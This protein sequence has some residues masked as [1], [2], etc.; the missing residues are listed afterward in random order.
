MQRSSITNGYHPIIGNGFYYSQSTIQRI[1]EQL[2]ASAENQVPIMLP[3][4]DVGSDTRPHSVLNDPT[5]GFPDAPD[6]PMEART[7][8]NVEGNI[9]AGKNAL[10]ELLSQYKNMEICLEPMADW[11]N[12]HGMDPLRLSYL[13]PTKYAAAFQHHVFKTQTEIVQK[14]W[15]QPVRLIERSMESSSNVFLEALFEN[16]FINRLDY[17]I[18][19]EDYKTG[20]M[21]N[22]HTGTIYLDCD[23][24]T[25][26]QRV[27]RN[28]RIEGLSTYTYFQSVNH[29]YERYIKH[30]IDQGGQVIIIDT[31]GDW[32]ELAKISHVI[33]TCIEK[34]DMETLFSYR[35]QHLQDY[36]ELRQL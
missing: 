19:K 16:E 33:G 35:A 13:N 20:I 36:F 30:L 21:A 9:A 7:L 24:D 8:I 23:P 12:Y 27:Q 2:Q 15:V 32:K 34:N 17:Q 28:R 26:F 10:L 29:H 14:K 5:Q 6:A 1:A 31:S 22:R 3:E 4:D 11:R 18:L 25:A